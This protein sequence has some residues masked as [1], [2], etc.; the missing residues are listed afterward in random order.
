MKNIK[1]F[2]ITACI[3]LGVVIFKQITKKVVRENA[4][5]FALQGKESSVQAN[6][7]ISKVDTAITQQLWFTN[8]QHG[9]AFETPKAIKE[10]QMQI[11][12][13]TEEYFSAVYSYSFKDSDFLLNYSVMDSHFKTYDTKAGLEGA[14]KNFINTA[15]GSDVKLVFKKIQ[16]KNCHTCSGD[17]MFK[18][19]KMTVQGY[20]LFKKGRIFILIASGQDNE[21]VR[22][23]IDR[24]IG[25]IRTKT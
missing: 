3:L 23:K 9:L 22:K 14:V 1:V 10:E 18:G 5:D 16:D 20:S 25:S 11:P 6:S 17:L 13:G 2:A 4:I 21:L 12:Q 15:D 7:V 24:V 19:V 8:T